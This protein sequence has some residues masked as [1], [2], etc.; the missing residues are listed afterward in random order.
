VLT[1]S[2]SRLR[3]GWVTILVSRAGTGHIPFRKAGPYPPFHCPIWRSRVS[4]SHVAMPT[5]SG[6]HTRARIA[7]YGSSA[8]EQPHPAEASFA[9]SE[10]PRPVAAPTA[11]A[12]GFYIPVQGPVEDQDLVQRHNLPS[13]SRLPILPSAVAA[14]VATAKIPHQA[15]PSAAPDTSQDVQDHRWAVF[16]RSIT[17]KVQVLQSKIAKSREAGAQL[18]EEVLELRTVISVRDAVV[19]HRAE[20]APHGEEETVAKKKR[21]VKNTCWVASRTAMSRPMTRITQVLPKRLRRTRKRCVGRRLG[22]PGVG[23]LIGS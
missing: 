1:V 18:R 8:S 12:A 4:S 2:I 13:S 15:A 22:R 11:S 3:Q 21:K 20:K 17:K 6:A 10:P 5:S 23:V 19:C 16:C 14:P 7:A 9:R